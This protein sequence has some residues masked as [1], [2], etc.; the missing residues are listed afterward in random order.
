MQNT[1]ADVVP[2]QEQGGN[3]LPSP[4][5]LTCRKTF[6]SNNFLPKTQHIG[7][8]EIVDFGNRIQILRQ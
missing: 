7:L 5:T 3:H 1:L 2:M 6:L 8:L 4:Q